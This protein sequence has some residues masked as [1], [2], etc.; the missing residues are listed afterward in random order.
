[1]PSRFGTATG[2]GLFEPLIGR[3][4]DRGGGAGL[5]RSGL[6]PPIRARG[7]SGVPGREPDEAVIRGSGELIRAGDAARGTG[8]VR[9]DGNGRGTVAGDDV[10][11]EGRGGTGGGVRA[12]REVVGAPSVEAGERDRTGV[13]AGV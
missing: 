4:L 2:G 1:M 7:V 5:P 3:S 8:E 12:F 13:E 11:D 6:G 9:G 10:M